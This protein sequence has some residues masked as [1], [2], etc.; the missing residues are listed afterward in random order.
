M[1]LSKL[2]EQ[3]QTINEIVAHVMKHAVIISDDHSGASVIIDLP[4]SVTDIELEQLIN[5]T[6][7]KSEIEFLINWNGYP[8]IL[9]I[10]RSSKE[11][12]IK[13]LFGDHMDFDGEGQLP[14]F[15]WK[16]WSENTKY[17]IHY[18]EDNDFED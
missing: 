15:T 2:F 8:C 1:K 18:D 17:D 5:I 10:D 7:S 3:G 16:Q 11:S 6:F 12:I 4:A 14:A 13:S 9:D